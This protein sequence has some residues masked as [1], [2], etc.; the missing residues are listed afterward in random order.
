MDY[1]IIEKENNYKN[2]G[3]LKLYKN[4]YPNI[5]FNFDKLDLELYLHIDYNCHWKYDDSEIY[6]YIDERCDELDIKLIKLYDGNINGKIT[7]I[8]NYKK[9]EIDYSYHHNGYYKSIISYNIIENICEE[10]Y[11]TYDYKNI[12]IKSLGKLCDYIIE[13]D[14]DNNIKIYFIFE[15]K[16]L[17]ILVEKNT[18]YFLNE[19][20]FYLLKDIYCSKIII[21]ND[22]NKIEFY[23]NKNRILNYDFDTKILYDV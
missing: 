7:L 22:K 4:N 21:N 13:E 20:S 18:D 3:K 2:I 8:F 5:Y 9:L 10:N 11:L 12:K 19:Y 1:K 17:T 15:N 6:D 16:D 23:E 14:Y